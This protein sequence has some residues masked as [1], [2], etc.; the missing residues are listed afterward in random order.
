MRHN[1]V[2]SLTLLGTVLEQFLWHFHVKICDKTEINYWIFIG[3]KWEKML[4]INLHSRRITITSCISVSWIW[5]LAAVRQLCFMCLNNNNSILFQE[6]WTTDIL[7]HLL[8]NLSV[9]PSFHP[10]I[11]QWSI[12]CAIFLNQWERQVLPTLY[13]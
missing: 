12:H 8:L 6:L 7:E 10:S 9:Y 4:L 3:F 11:N 5:S 13:T 1:F 2:T